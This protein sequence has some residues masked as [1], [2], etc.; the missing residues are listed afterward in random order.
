MPLSNTER[1]RLFRLRKAGKLPPYQ[2]LI[3][4]TCGASHRGARGNICSLCWRKTPEGLEYVR[5]TVAKSRA[6]RANP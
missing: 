6:R 5:Q 1:Q 3:C 2:P 4:S